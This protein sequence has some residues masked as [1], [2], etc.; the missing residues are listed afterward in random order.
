MTKQEIWSRLEEMFGDPIGW[1]TGSFI[2]DQ[3]VAR[4]EMHLTMHTFAEKANG[5]RWNIRNQ[6]WCESC[7][8]K[9]TDEQALRVYDW[10][11]DN[12]WIDDE[13]LEWRRDRVLE[14]LNS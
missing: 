9:I 12:G 8:W 10:L 7:A 4:V 6:E 3:L 2:D 14:R 11:E 13:T 5:W 1:I